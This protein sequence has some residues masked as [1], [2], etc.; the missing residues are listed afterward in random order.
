MFDYMNCNKIRDKV[1]LAMINFIVFGFLYSTVDR[2]EVDFDN[3]DITNSMMHSFSTQMFEYN[4]KKTY[5]WAFVLT[6]IQIFISYII[7][8]S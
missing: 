7:I 4:L 3:A 6:I 8:V 1:L 2:K 5:G